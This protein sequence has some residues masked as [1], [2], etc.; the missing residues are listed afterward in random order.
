MFYPMMGGTGCEL[1]PRGRVGCDVAPNMGETGDELEPIR[2]GFD[3]VF[4]PK[5]IGPGFKF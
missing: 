2:G 5:R 1:Y 3:C 4:C